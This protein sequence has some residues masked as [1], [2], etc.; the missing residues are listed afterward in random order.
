VFG[1]PKNASF[2]AATQ[3][4]ASEAPS[5]FL[6]RIEIRAE[7]N[8]NLLFYS[9]HVLNGHVLPPPSGERREGRRGR[10]KRKKR[11]VR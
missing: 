6:S 5:L 7:E 9:L 8:E 1:L 10:G 3:T 4:L 11:M 2:L